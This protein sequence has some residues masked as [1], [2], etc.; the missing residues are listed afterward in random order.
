MKKKGE[1]DTQCDTV[2]PWPK[3]DGIEKVTYRTNS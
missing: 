2:F 3:V 1:Q